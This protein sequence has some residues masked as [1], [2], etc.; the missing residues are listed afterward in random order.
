MGGE[1]SKDSR[2]GEYFLFADDIQDQETIDFLRAITHHPI[3]DDHNY[4][5]NLLA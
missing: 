3:D 4:V 1:I 2:C 5:P